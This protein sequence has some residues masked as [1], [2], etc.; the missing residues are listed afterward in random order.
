MDEDLI[1]EARERFM[2]RLNYE[3]TAPLFGARFLATSDWQTPSEFQETLRH[4]GEYIAVLEARVD[5]LE[6]A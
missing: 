1:R 5:R 6:K 2:Q 3:G 4:L